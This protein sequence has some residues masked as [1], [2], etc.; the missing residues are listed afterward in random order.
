M[1]KAAKKSKNYKVKK[2]RSLA[3][4]KDQEEMIKNMDT[5]G[6][7]FIEVSGRRFL[8]SGAVAKMYFE[9]T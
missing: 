5:K 3:F 1:G 4:K 8:M 2:D 9:Q 6:F 7:Y